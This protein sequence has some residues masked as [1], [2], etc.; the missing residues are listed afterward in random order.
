MAVDI[1][2]PYGGDISWTPEEAPTLVV[3]KPG[4]PAAT[5]QMVTV[6]V[7]QQPRLLDVNGVGVGRPD[8]WFYPDRGGGLRA[9]VGLAPDPKPISDMKARIKAGLATS[10]AVAATP[11][12]M[13][14]DTVVGATLTVTVS[15]QTSDGD[16]IQITQSST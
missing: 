5:Q 16:L 1:K 9:I 3:D 15:C 2:L 14:T 4:D 8:N 7:M 13:V 10:D 6:L 11:A 12:P